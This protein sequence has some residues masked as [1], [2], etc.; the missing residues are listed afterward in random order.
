[1]LESVKRPVAGC[2]ACVGGLILA[3]LLAYRVATF[4]RFD[5]A[6][7]RR[8]SEYK[9]SSLGGV[10]TLI[11]DLGDPLPQLAMLGLVC[12][13]ALRWGRPRPAVGAVVLV[14]GANVT[15]QALKAMLTHPHHQLIVGYRQ[16]EVGS[17]PSGHATAVM[18]MA[19]AFLLVVPRSWRPGTMVVGAGA[20]VAVGC[21][22]VILHRHYPSDV[23]GGWLVGAGWF[24]AVIAGLR[25]VE[26]GSPRR[27]AGLAG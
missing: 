5:A 22:V 1:V 4:E 18:S 12:L 14:A 10:A 25:A 15:S 7:L 9:E 2:L 16:V 20:V 11:A 19:L 26:E 8:L 23:I 27:R 24:F 3:A 13:M 21:S 6:V 17:F